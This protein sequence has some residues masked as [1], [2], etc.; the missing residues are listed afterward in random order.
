VLLG[1]VLQG[2]SLYDLLTAGAEEHNRTVKAIVT[3]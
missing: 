1:A 2:T 3:P